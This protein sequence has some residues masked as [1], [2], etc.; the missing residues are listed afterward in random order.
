M[1]APIQILNLRIRGIGTFTRP[2]LSEIADHD[3][4]NSAALGFKSA[5][6]F[7]SRSP[8]KFSLYDRRKLG[9]GAVVEGPAL[10]DEGTSVTVIHSNQVLSVDRY[11][12]LIISTGA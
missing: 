5:F 11:G 2:K 12:N 9:K 1:D 10:I 8:A 7:M 3:P 4:S 6:C